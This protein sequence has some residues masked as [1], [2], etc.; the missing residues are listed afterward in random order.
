[1]DVQIEPSSLQVRSGYAFSNF[2]QERERSIVRA[3]AMIF[4]ANSATE[5]ARRFQ[6][7]A[8][9]QLKIHRDHL[10]TPQEQAAAW[11]AQDEVRGIRS[12]G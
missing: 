9:T 6:R 1:M 2:D 7:K 4:E 3:K 10:L 5:R 8:D 11:S 12:T